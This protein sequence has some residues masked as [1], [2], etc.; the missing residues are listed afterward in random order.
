MKN[1]QRLGESTFTIAAWGKKG[2]VERMLRF[3]C[4]AGKELV[5]QCGPEVLVNGWILV[6][7]KSRDLNCL[8]SQYFPLPHSTVVSQVHAYI[9]VTCSVYVNK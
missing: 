7:L 2:S 4:S 8:P 3:K 6:P 1:C 5:P 9:P